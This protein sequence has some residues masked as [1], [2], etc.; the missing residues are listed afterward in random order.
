MHSN[1]FKYIK[2]Y[3]EIYMQINSNTFKYIQIHSNIFKYIEMYYK[4]IELHWNT[5]PI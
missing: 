2:I 3:F 1:T 4:C 5:L